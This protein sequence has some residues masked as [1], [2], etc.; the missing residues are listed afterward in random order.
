MKCDKSRV[1]EHKECAT[2]VVDESLHGK[3]IDAIDKRVGLDWEDQGMKSVPQGAKVLFCSGLRTPSKKFRDRY[4]EIAWEC[5][6]CGKLHP[7]GECK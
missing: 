2:C 1:E 3:K 7:K 6:K 5:E 4:D